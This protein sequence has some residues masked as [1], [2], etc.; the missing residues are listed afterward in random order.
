MGFKHSYGLLTSLCVLGEGE[1]LIGIS[2]C[3]KFLKL[4]AI[5]LCCCD[6]LPFFSNSTVKI[7]VFLIGLPALEPLSVLAVTLGWSGVLT[8]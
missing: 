3:M 4:R 7:Y 5:M 1:I 8:G 2:Q 6:F